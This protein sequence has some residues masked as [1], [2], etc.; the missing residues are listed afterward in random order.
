M[1]YLINKRLKLYFTLIFLSSFLA[2]NAT[3]VP[4]PNDENR[5]LNQDLLNNIF[6]KLYNL[7]QNK[8]GKVNIVHIG[9]SHIQAD[10]FTNVIRQALQSDFGNGGYG[11]TFPYRLIGTNGSYSVKYVSNANWQSLLNVY[12]VADIGV[13]LSGIALYTN[14]KDFILE[15]SA[16]DKYEFNTIKVIYPTVEPQYRISVTPDPLEVTSTTV[17]SNIATGQ[18]TR[19]HKIKSGE[20]LSTIARKYG[21]TV[22]QIKSA[23]GLKSN[24][25]RAGK[26]L[27][28]PTKGGSRTT[29]S[30]TRVSTIKVNEDIEYVDMVSKPYYSTY[31]SDSL[32]SR[33]AIVANEKSATHNLNG[34]V[35]ENDKPGVIYHSIGVNGAKL[36]DYNK[37]PLFYKQL[38]ILN[39]DL[40]IL[41]FGTNE[42]FGKLSASEY[43]YQVRQFVENI[44]TYCG[45]NVTVLVMTPP[46][47]LFRRRRENPF[48]SDYSMALMQM[49]KTPVWDLYTRMGGLDGIRK[50]NLIARDNV[51][52]TQRGYETQGYMFLEDFTAA[53]DQFKKE[54]RH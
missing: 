39:P 33:I 6:E 43:I 19:T 42:S 50:S 44:K 26:S 24:S 25:I 23:N 35:I 11:F 48:V 27:R 29:K 52:Y 49:S 53:Y 54:R 20:N 12:P 47:S 14:T 5:F 28:I 18:S 13:G 51:H 32:L 38:P 4:K 40:V 9:D 34:F 2:I 7:Q 15:L 1:T 8:K 16:E 45:Q 37:Y 46:P 31:T 41:S 10:I 17:G 3:N 21:V 22:T 36:S 30:K